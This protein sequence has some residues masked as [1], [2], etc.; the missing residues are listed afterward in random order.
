MNEKRDK[1]LLKKCR[2]KAEIPITIA[3]IVI[4]ILFTVL[5]IF[6]FRSSATNQTAQD[7][8]INNL[9]YE[10]TDVDFA[11]KSGKYLIIVIIIVLII[12]LFW[13][14]FK[15]A[16]IAVVND[17]PM[18]ESYDPLLFKEYKEYC[19]K[20]GIEKTPEIYL[21]GDKENLESTGITI[22]SSKYLRIDS[23]VLFEEEGTIRFEFLHEL[24]HIAYK[25]YNYALLLAT[26]VVRWAPILRSIYSRI[27]CYSADRL[28]AEILGK[29]ECI[30]ILLKKYLLSTYEEDKRDKY[31]ERLDRK[32]TF[33]ER[34]S[35]ILNN[36]TSDTPS[37][38]Y[39]IQALAKDDNKGRLI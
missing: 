33:T 11:L 15:N 22:K 26:I 13:E 25:H 12:K 4:T 34:L 32:L 36:L 23:S 21:A 39:R 29:E 16:G 10:E 37:Y 35:S 1:D 5:V 2:H 31:I 7:F 20:L 38:L 17:I 30:T 24:A 8:L 3:A 9:E 14:L 27:M 18:E 6:L 28:A 19:E